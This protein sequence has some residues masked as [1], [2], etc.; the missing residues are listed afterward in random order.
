M[1]ATMLY[2][3]L[4]AASTFDAPDATCPQ[5]AAQPKILSIVAGHDN[6]NRTHLLVSNMWRVHA[7]ATSG[8]IELV[9]CL[10]YVHA[11]ETVLPERF[12]TER[13]PPSCTVVRRPSDSLLGHLMS[14]PA[15]LISQADYVATSIDSVSFFPDVD[16]EMLARIMADNCLHRASPACSTCKTKRTINHVYAYPVGRLMDFVDF[17]GAL[18]FDPSTHGLWEA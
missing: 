9:G 10:I 14:I 7:M 15:D 12:L 6:R 16:L 11:S 8:S 3:L 13:L 4:L 2:P 5:P 17:I 18:R 1:H